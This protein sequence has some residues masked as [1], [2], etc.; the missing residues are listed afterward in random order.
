MEKVKIEDVNFEVD[1]SGESAVDEEKVHVTKRIF[2]YL[3]PHQTP[4]T[5][6]VLEQDKTFIFGPE[7]A[8]MV[9]H[10]NDVDEL[11]S[12]IKDIDDKHL[13]T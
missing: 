7:E 3:P 2:H 4:W 6:C 8:F 12:A 10:T 9:A 11:L 5:Y 1:C 13:L